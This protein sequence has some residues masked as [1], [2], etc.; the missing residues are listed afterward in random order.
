MSL[1]IPARQLDIT[2]MGD[3]RYWKWTRLP[4]PDEEEEV[5]EL[6]DVC[7]LNIVGKVELK[8]LLLKTS[9]SAYLV[10]KLKEPSYGLTKA[11]ARV[12]FAGGA[13][14]HPDGEVCSVF[15]SKKKRPGERGIFPQPRGKRWMEIKLGEFFNDLGDCGLGHIVEAS[16]F[17]IQEP[18]WK[19]G[20]L[21]RGIE[22][23]PNY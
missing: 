16:L 10:F 3:P 11:T 6:L 2:W 17:E 9:Y 20:L 15:I 18:N 19:S 23:L 12:R 8:K 22:L 14:N 7:W 13:G 4:P 1:W 21:V 5:A